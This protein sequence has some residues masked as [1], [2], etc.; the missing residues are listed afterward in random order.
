[1]ITEYAWRAKRLRDGLLAIPDVRVAMPGGGFY[2]FPNVSAYLRDGETTTDLAGELL[3]EELV[4]VVPGIAFGHD[5]YL[6]T[7]FA[8]SRDRIE[9]GI[10]RLQR[11]FAARPAS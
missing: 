6:R 11:F 5:G 9:E 1:M 8:C 7:S 2:L 4:A 10:V 3:S